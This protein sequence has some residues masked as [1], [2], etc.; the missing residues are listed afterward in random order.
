MK[1]RILFCLCTLL[2][3][4]SAWA[5]CSQND[6]RKLLSHADTT[7]IE[8]YVRSNLCDLDEDLDG[9]SKVPLVYAIEAHKLE[10]VKI[11]LN[12]G[13][14]PNADGYD[15][16]TP[17]FYATDTKDMS[18]VQALVEQGANVNAFTRFSNRTVLMNA[19]QGST[20]AIVAYLVAHK[21]ALDE[22][23]KYNHKAAYYVSTLPISQRAAMQ[24]ALV[25][26]SAEAINRP[27]DA[28]IT[29]SG[30]TLH[31]HASQ[32]LVGSNP[33]QYSVK[34]LF[35][36]DPAKAWVFH[37]EEKYKLANDLKAPVVVTMTLSRPSPLFAIM[38]TPGYNKSTTTQFQNSSPR[39]IVVSLYR[40]NEAKPFE[41][42]RFMLSYHAR[43]YKFSALK[44][45]LKTVE[46]NDQTDNNIIGKSDNRINSAERML[47]INPTGGAV[48]KVE[49]AISAIE[50]GAKFTDVAISKLRLL[51]TQ[52]DQNTEE[53]R[54]AQF[55]NHDFEH[56][57]RDLIDMPRCIVYTTQNRWPLLKDQVCTAP[58]P[59]VQVGGPDDG[60]ED[61]IFTHQDPATH[62]YQ[63]P[64]NVAL[65][66]AVSSTTGK[67]KHLRVSGD[68]V[69]SGELII[70]KNA[71]GQ[72]QAL[73]G[74]IL[75][76]AYL[77][78]RQGGF[79]KAYMQTDDEQGPSSYFFFGYSRLQLTPNNGSY[80]ASIYGPVGSQEAKW[81]A[82]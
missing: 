51:D 70:S 36:Q 61:I 66:N 19:I 13:A 77:A 4:Q 73:T 10:A 54:L 38:M 69:A 18:I 37:G 43:D 78:S 72:I 55:I 57:M 1:F 48:A 81:P 50:R 8:A 31:I 71:A 29:L 11:L 42:K 41:S 39:T 6:W 34:N 79:G 45:E 56:A 59:Q 32:T 60:I 35:D 33:D 27:E 9:E 44:Q 49:I 52:A 16:Q 58:A 17:L 65:R 68:D 75:N 74:L 76:Q 40:P 82:F 80:R 3:A 26:P 22:T 53:Y 30:N 67:K 63:I 23:D 14:D 47:L 62:E 46:F 2:C 24:A 28:K 15:D 20:P 21:A 25:K 7:A 12:F 5:A 64:F